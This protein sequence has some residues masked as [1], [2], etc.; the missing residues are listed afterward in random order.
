MYIDKFSNNWSEID[1]MFNV[2]SLSFAQSGTRSNCKLFRMPCLKLSSRWP[3]RTWASL[4]TASRF[5][6]STS[7]QDC[8]GLATFTH[9]WCP[10]S[11]NIRIKWQSRVTRDNYFYLSNSWIKCVLLFLFSFHTCRGRELVQEFLISLYRKL[12]CSVFTTKSF[13]VSIVVRNKWFTIV[14]CLTTFQFS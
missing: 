1:P 9:S 14:I 3:A 4:R 11:H 2:F 13:Y 8:R 12:I 6:C 10:C 5:T 7:C